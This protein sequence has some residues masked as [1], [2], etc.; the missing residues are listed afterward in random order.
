MKDTAMAKMCIY[1]QKMELI[2][3]LKVLKAVFHISIN[4]HLSFN[5]Q[6]NECSKFWSYAQES[7]ASQRGQPLKIA[8]C[9]HV[10][11]SFPRQ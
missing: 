9:M 7:C 3:G 8:H 11:N 6:S 4:V 10:N 5:V 2:K 1:G